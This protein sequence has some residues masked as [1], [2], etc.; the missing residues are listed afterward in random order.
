MPIDRNEITKEQ[1]AKAMQCKSAEELIAFAKSE[2]IDITKEEAGRI[3]WGC[4]R[5]SCRTLKLSIIHA[6]SEFCE[7]N[8]ATV[9]DLPR[10]FCYNDDS[11][12]TKQTASYHWE[13]M[14]RQF[15]LHLWGC[16]LLNR[17]SVS[18]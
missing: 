18:A 3:V 7:V 14:H 10:L 15:S 1:I 4:W 5:S 2:G 12:I 16:C 11:D 6:K 9:V 13:R 17:S 8:N